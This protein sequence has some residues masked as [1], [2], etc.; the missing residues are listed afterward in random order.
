LKRLGGFLALIFGCCCENYAAMLSCCC[1]KRNGRSK[2]GPIFTTT[3]FISHFRIILFSIILCL[4][5]TFDHDLLM[6]TAV[7]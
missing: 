1:Q 4:S 2:K 5:V 3:K 6:F 7:L